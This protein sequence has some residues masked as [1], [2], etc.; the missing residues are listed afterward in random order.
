MR[1]I[2]KIWSFLIQNLA[3]SKVWR[4]D[5]LKFLISRTK[6]LTMVGSNV[7]YRHIRVL[8]QY[9]IMQ[10]KYRKTSPWQSPVS[11]WIPRRAFSALL[12]QEMN[13]QWRK[14]N[15]HF[16]INIIFLLSLKKKIEIH[17]FLR[18][19]QRKLGLISQ[20]RRNASIKKGFG[21]YLNLVFKVFNFS[22]KFDAYALLEF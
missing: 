11:K 18:I 4:V 7:Q 6:K 15:L 13:V 5:W 3:I 8:H 16:F 14:E 12:L 21:V 17:F 20:S 9:C 2:L 10:R 22:S 1:N 19:F